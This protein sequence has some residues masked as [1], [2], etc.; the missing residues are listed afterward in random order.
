MMK[1]WAQATAAR[2][3]TLAG[4]RDAPVGNLQ[5]GFD[6]V[7]KEWAELPREGRR[8]FESGM[9]A[10]G[11]PVEVSLRVGVNGAPPR[12]RFIAQPGMPGQHP[13]A[14][15]RFSCTRALEF[16]DRWCGAMALSVVNPLLDLFVSPTTSA[17]NFLLWLGLEQGADSTI[18]KLYVN[19]WE[20]ASDIRGTLLLEALLRASGF[21]S[22][23]PAF[24][25]VVFIQDGLKLQVIGMNLT[26][27]GVETIK[28]YVVFDRVQPRKLMEVAALFN[29]ERP[30]A[31]AFRA[32]APEPELSGQAHA[33][34]V[35]RRGQARPRFRASLY[36]PHWFSSDRQV[37]DVAEALCGSGP[38]QSNDPPTGGG[39]WYT[40]LGVEPEG[41]TLYSRV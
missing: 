7:A 5:A 26:E 22:V 9:T 27:H 28:A 21:G 23:L 19:P 13:L 8:P 18:A 11:L 20:A 16:I 1:T 30:L 2:F 31:T 35:W 4:G 34:L 33:A 24:E 36:C 40:F 17:G 12:V 37:I 38:P 25:D 39:R 3:E 10:D 14:D 41:A 32:L 6:C 15:R 29:D